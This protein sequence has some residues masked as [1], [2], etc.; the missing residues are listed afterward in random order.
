M[1]ARVNRT[2]ASTV[3]LFAESCIHKA[4]AECGFTPGLV[5]LADAKAEDEATSRWADCRFAYGDRMA[6]PHASGTAGRGLWRDGAVVAGTCRRGDA[7]DQGRD[8]GSPHPAPPV[9]GS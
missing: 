9:E 6:R 5:G 8:P 1:D 7:V 4:V 2:W 3:R